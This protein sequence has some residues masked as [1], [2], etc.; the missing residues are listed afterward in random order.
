MGELESAFAYG[1]LSEFVKEELRA[2]VYTIDQTPSALL[3]LFERRHNYG[4][5]RAMLDALR[6]IIDEKASERQAELKSDIQGR[7]QSNPSPRLAK[8]L[9]AA[10][11]KLEEPERNFVVA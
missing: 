7:Q 8:M 6:K 2:A 10:L 9:Q 11:Q 4:C 5:L 3:E 1:R